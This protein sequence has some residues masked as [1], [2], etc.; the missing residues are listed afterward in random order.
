MRNALPDNLQTSWGALGALVVVLLALALLALLARGGSWSGG[1]LQW[2]FNRPPAVEQP[3]P[4]PPPASQA[5]APTAARLPPRREPPAAPVPPPPKPP[6]ANAADALRQVL[7]DYHGDPT[8][9]SSVTVSS[10]GKITV[11]RDTGLTVD[12]GLSMQSIDHG[13]VVSGAR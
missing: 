1:I 9:T 7:N 8:R 6:P 4:A 11:H 5:T 12:D 2:Q 13:T 10:T 3:A